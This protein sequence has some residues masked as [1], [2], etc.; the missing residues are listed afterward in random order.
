[1]R[2]E[3]EGPV[4]AA[5]A[6]SARFKERKTSETREGTAAKSQRPLPAT[7][8]TSA[9]SPVRSAERRGRASPTPSQSPPPS[10]DATH[11]ARRLIGVESRSKTPQKL[12]TCASSARLARPGALVVPSS[13]LTNQSSV[14]LEAAFDLG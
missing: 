6:E 10:S 11:Y 14:G 13:L 12:A 7:I 4:L 3:V 8:T 5:K 2:G 9:P 1:M